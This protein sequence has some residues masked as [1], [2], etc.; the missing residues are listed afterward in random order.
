MN[1]INETYFVRRFEH[2]IN[3]VTDIRRCGYGQMPFIP[4]TFSLYQ[5]AP[6]KAFFIG[7]DTYYWCDYDESYAN[8]LRA[9]MKDNAE[10]VTI[11]NYQN[12]W[13]TSGSFWGMVGKMQLQLYTGKYYNSIEELTKN[14]WK[15][16]DSVG[17]GNLFPLE[18][19]STLKKKKYNYGHKGIERNEYE[20]I[21]DRVSYRT[22]QRK[23]Q[24]F[25]NLKAI[26]EAYGE[27]DVVFILSWSGS[28]KIFFE[29]LDYE[30]KNEWYE[31]GLREVYLSKT[32][33]TKV[34]WSSH[35]RRFSFLETN[36]QEMCQYLCDTYHALDREY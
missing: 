21:V 36:P 3:D 16:L 30:S 27:P 19:P 28:E 15:I 10:Y 2:I 35:P 20:D 34:I 17:Y 32:H 25:C 18:L 13:S 14:E 26:F 12:D 23:F 9:Y 29:G 33:K 22:L 31:H 11:D 7:R 6:L 24:S 8:N 1:N 5:S 4:Y